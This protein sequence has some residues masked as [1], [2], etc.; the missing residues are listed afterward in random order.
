MDEDK[1]DLLEALFFAGVFL[2]TSSKRSKEKINYSY[3][4]VIF[5]IFASGRNES[6][7]LTFL[8]SRFLGWFFLG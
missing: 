7:R 6:R 3:I 4:L 8:S 5:D 1:I 2:G